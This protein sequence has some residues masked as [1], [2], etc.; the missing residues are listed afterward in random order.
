MSAIDWENEVT[1][2]LNRCDWICP[3]NHKHPGICDHVRTLL[4]VIESQRYMMWPRE[5]QA[6][7]YCADELIGMMER[8]LEDD[9][10][11]EAEAIAREAAS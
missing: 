10:V 1:D 2:M 6:L 11:A 8:A 3:A 5:R 9:A 4:S 7:L